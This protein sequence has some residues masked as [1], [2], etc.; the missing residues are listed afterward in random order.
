MFINYEEVSKL[1]NCFLQ[2]AIETAEGEELTL[3]QKSFPMCFVNEM[4]PKLK[5]VPVSL[6]IKQR[7]ML[8]KRHNML[9]E[10]L[11]A[12]LDWT[13]SL[14]M[15]GIPL[16]SY[17]GVPGGSDE[18]E[19]DLQ[20]MNILLPQLKGKTYI[21]PMKVKI[22]KKEYVIVN[23]HHDRDDVEFGKKFPIDYNISLIILCEARWIDF[24][25]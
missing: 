16:V 20:M 7:E 9:G 18:I 22:Y 13:E 6:V 19:R 14:E 24:N 3:L 12:Y 1:K 8:L 17:Y 10:D 21:H 23:L 15:L 25:K 11:S 2:T 4:V 5:P